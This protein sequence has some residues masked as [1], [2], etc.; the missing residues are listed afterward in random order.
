MSN[1]T[2][3]GSITDDKSLFELISDIGNNKISAMGKAANGIPHAIEDLTIESLVEILNDLTVSN[4]VLFGMSLVIEEPMKVEGEPN[5]F[6][7]TVLNC[8]SNKKYRIFGDDKQL[9]NDSP[10]IYGI[11]DRKIKFKTGTNLTEVLL[12]ILRKLDKPQFTIEFKDVY[13]FH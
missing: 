2:I 3:I 1:E 7:A 10:F 9:D 8:F 11:I 13:K 12:P 5:V 4:N 6:S